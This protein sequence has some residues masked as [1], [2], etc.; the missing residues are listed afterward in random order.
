MRLIFI[1]EKEIKSKECTTQ[2]D[3]AGTLIYGIGLIPL[4]TI[5]LET[6]MEAI[7]VAFADG[8]TAARI[9]EMLQS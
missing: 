9:W 8:I 6:I 1:V 2:D 4:L 3:S 7:I 5:V